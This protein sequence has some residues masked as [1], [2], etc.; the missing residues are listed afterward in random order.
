MVIKSRPRYSRLLTGRR[1]IKRGWFG[2]ALMYVEVKEGSNRVWRRCKTQEEW[3]WCGRFDEGQDKLIN[4]ARPRFRHKGPV[5]T[6]D[7]DWDEP[8]LDQPHAMR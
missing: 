8:P 6:E 7:Y 5:T 3:D 1:E 2:I 4:L